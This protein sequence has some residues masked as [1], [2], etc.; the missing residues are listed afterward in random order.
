MARTKT[1]E[2]QMM[3]EI[4]LKTNPHEGEHPHVRDLA[5]IPKVKKK[6]HYIQEPGGVLEFTRGVTVVKNNGKLGTV[7]EKYKM[8]D[9]EEVEIPPYIATWLSSIFYPDK[10]QKRPRFLLTDV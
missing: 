1:R 9:G 8:T 7:Y 3:E 10:D 5:K 2:S 6:F 4:P